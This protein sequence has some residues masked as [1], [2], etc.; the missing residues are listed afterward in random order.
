[1]KIKHIV[2]CL[3]WFL[4]MCCTFSFIGT[5]LVID[6]IGIHTLPLQSI[7]YTGFLKSIP[8]GILSTFTFAAFIWHKHR[9]SKM[10][11]ARDLTDDI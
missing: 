9:Q 7:F 1:M 3:L 11:N 4:T 2:Q 8:A 10:Q 5:Y 6:T